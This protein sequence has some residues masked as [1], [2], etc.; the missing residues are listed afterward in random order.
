MKIY[1]DI[2]PNTGD[3]SGEA[4]DHRVDCEDW[5]SYQ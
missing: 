4:R 1:S 3:S 5:D 2:A